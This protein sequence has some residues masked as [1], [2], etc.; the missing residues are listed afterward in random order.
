VKHA[1]LVSIII[2]CYNYA[3]YIQQ[4]IESAAAQ[5][6]PSVEVIVINDGSTDNSDTVIKKLKEQYNFKYFSQENRGIIATRNRGVELSKGTYELQL[7][8]DDYLEPTYVEKCV[9]T[10]EKFDA[11]IVYTQVHMFGRADF[12]SNYIDYDLEKLKHDNYIHA[13]ALVKRDVLKKD[14]YDTYLGDKGYEDWDLFLGLCLDGSTAKLVDE[15]LLHYRKHSDRKSR[16]DDFA[17]V[18]KEMLV[19]HHIW[20]K[21]NAKHPDEFWYFSSQIQTLGEMIKMYTLCKE[22]Q[23]HTRRL[24]SRLRKMKGIRPAKLYGN[25]KRHLRSSDNS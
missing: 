10:A 15:P 4:A 13:T 9:R 8:A 21:Q 12:N 19:R 3:E 2:T 6:Y 22:Q 25:I 23:E 7:D 16:S 5:T 18:Y 11:D 20:N 24:E 1:P 17:D 14:P